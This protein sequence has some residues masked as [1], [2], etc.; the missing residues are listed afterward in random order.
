[1]KSE[2]VKLKKAVAKDHIPYDSLHRI[3]VDWAEKLVVA[4]TLSGRESNSIMAFLFRVM[5]IS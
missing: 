1:M 3:C 2:N 5:K 4:G